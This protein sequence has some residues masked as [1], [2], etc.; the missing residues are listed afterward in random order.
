MPMI[1]LSSCLA[2]FAVRYDGRAA[3]NNL[4]I[5]LAER[6]QAVTVCPE[7]ASG[8]PTPRQPAEIVGG[9]GSDVLAGRAKVIGRSGTDLT[10]AFIAGARLMLAIAQ[11]ND[12]KV[13]FLKDKSPSC[14]ASRIYDGSFSGSKISGSG[15]SA[16]LL[17]R[18][19]IQVYPDS[20]L[21]A[22]NVLPYV[23]PSVRS[24]L[25]TAFG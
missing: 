8:L 3:T 5:W 7:V 14:G 4:A 17:S 15:V 10:A 1:L 24:Q 6:G 21:T 12:V 9:T 18:N 16:E 25:T 23:D 20:A 22:S 11:Q 2:G 19:G 13:A